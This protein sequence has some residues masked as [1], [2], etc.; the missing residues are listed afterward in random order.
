MDP[1]SEPNEPV[2]FDP[3]VIRQWAREA[4]M[5]LV[6]VRKRKNAEAE[7]EKLT[8]GLR[9]LRSRFPIEPEDPFPVSLMLAVEHVYPHNPPLPLSNLEAEAE[10]V[11]R[12]LEALIDS[13]ARIDDDAVRSVEEFFRHL[14]MRAAA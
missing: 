14:V 13:P 1:V 7:R 5:S 11:S 2:E 10:V 12:Q 4:L 9:L 6:F 8:N 3:A